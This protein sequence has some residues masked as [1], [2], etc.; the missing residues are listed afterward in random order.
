MYEMLLEEFKNN[1]YFAEDAINWWRF[2]QDLLKELSFSEYKD[3]KE[4]V[5]LLL[6]CDSNCC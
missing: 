3:L 1:C 5:D 2:R 4:K 6:E